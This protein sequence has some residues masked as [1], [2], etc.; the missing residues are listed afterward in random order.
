M[1][2]LSLIHSFKCASLSRIPL[3]HF[4]TLFLITILR[5]NKLKPQFINVNFLPFTCR[6]FPKPHLGAVFLW[7]KKIKPFFQDTRQDYKGL[8]TFYF[9][10]Y[11]LNKNTDSTPSPAEELELIQAGLG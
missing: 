7:E 4:P 10:V 3:F 11:L 9:S 2:S 8:E 1:L 6:S 5:L